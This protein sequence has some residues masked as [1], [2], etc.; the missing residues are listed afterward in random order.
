M[1]A[2]PPIRARVVWRSGSRRRSLLYAVG[3]AAHE[4]VLNTVRLFGEQVIS[5]FRAEEKRAA[6]N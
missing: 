6:A 5:H 1:L 2:I 4:G 3:P